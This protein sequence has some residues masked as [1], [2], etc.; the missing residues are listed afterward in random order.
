MDLLFRVSALGAAFGGRWIFRG[1]NL[2]AERGE[3]ISLIGAS[4]CGKTTFLR[5]LAG[6]QKPTEGVIDQR[7]RRIACV[8][9]TPRLIP[10]LTVRRNL[11]FVS[12][13]S[14]GGILDALGLAGTEELYPHQL[15]GGMRQRVELARALLIEPDLLILD[16]AFS[17]LDVPLKLRI[18]EDLGALWEARRFTLVAVTHNPRDALLTSDRVVLLGGTPTSPVREF[19]LPPSAHRNVFDPEVA[20]VE[21]EI[22]RGLF[23][24]EPEALSHRGNADPGR[25]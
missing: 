18:F 6:L 17:S 7:A 9:Q 1:L 5:V 3:R 24:G 12:E 4:G 22:L 10:W 13:R 14:P 19:R 20:A 25:M 15:S 8:F 21:S 11:S 23:A 16:E 2:E